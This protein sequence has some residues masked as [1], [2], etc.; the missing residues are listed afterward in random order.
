MGTFRKYTEEFRE[1][2]FRE[3]VNDYG[4]SYR[5]LSEKYKVPLDSVKM[6]LSRKSTCGLG[7]NKTAGQIAR[8]KRNKA[9]A[10]E[11]GKVQKLLADAKKLR[12]SLGPKYGLNTNTAVKI[13]REKLA[14]A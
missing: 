6:M 11:Y 4:S 5:S 13:A 9:I 14:K 10:A 1:L 2:L 7:P 12:S 3:Y 8:A